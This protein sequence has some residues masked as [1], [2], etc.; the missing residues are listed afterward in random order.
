[1]STPRA[2]APRPALVRLLI[3]L[4]IVV[5]VFIA[6]IA[7][8]TLRP[9]LGALPTALLSA[10]IASIGGWAA[11]VAY[12]HRFE[13]RAALELA[14][15]GAA[16]ELGAG[17]AIGVGAFAASI[18]ILALLGVYRAVGVGPLLP[19]AMAFL[20]AIASGTI[21]EI[22]FRGV[23]FRL[24]E[25]WGGTWTALAVS[26]LLFGLGHLVNPHA[27]ALG[28]IA[29]VFEGGI[30]LAGA[31]LV[32]R[33]LWLP[34]G[35]HAGWNFA[36]AGIFGVPTSGAPMQ[37]VLLGELTGPEWLSGGIFG[38]EASIVAVLVCVGVGSALLLRAARKKRFVAA[39]RSERPAPL[40]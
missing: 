11:Y 1:M 16:R 7:V 32:T 9:T 38:P 14:G 37:G 20:M 18:G 17:I 2:A 29:I 31:Y 25:E 3:A 21:E 10:L 36:E 24:V 15:P 26:S 8:W 22:V 40:A 30:L 27:T 33:R 6:Q 28:A 12:V 19:V 4:A 23:L 39:R 5:P 35:V 34:I 13:R